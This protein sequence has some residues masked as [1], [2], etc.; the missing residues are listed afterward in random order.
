MRQ[1]TGIECRYE[2]KIGERNH[3]DTAVFIYYLACS[4]VSGEAQNLDDEENSEVE[5]VLATEAK[6]RISTD[7]SPEVETFLNEL[8]VGKYE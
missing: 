2:K 7:L 8:S 6:S 5:W 3:P 4:Y 1:E